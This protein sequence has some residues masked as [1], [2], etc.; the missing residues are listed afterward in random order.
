MNAENGTTILIPPKI[1]RLFSCHVSFNFHP[2]SGDSEW[3]RLVQVWVVNVRL[4]GQFHLESWL[5]VAS[6]YSFRFCMK[7][8]NIWFADGRS[9]HTVMQY[10]PVSLLFDNCQIV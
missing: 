7:W 5:S 2:F 6:A 1:L 9:A 8:T 10:M 3:S 4:G